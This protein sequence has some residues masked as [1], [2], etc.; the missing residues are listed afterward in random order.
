MEQT[1]LNKLKYSS[2][3]E[4]FGKM[5]D[6][7][8]KYGDLPFDSLMSAFSG[9]SMF[10]ND[11]YSQNA[12]IKRISTSPISY[13]KD[14]VAGFLKTPYTSEAELRQTEH[15]L[16]I[17]S[18]PLYHIRRTYTSM[19]TY[20]SF[21]APVLMDAEDMKAKDFWRE[22]RLV[23]KLRRTFDPKTF[24]HRTGGQAQQEGKV[25][26]I[27]RAD[28]DKPHN[29]VNHA[30][31]QQLPSDFCKIV[32]FNNKSKYTIAFNLMYF[33]L[34]GTDPRQFG[35]LF[36]P[37]MQD[38]NQVVYPEP[39]GVGGKLVY[40][41]A[42]KINLEKI[43]DNEADAYYQN[44]KWFYWVT[45]PITKVHTIEADDVS[46]AVFSPFSGLFINMIQLSQIEALQ[47]QLYQNP[48]IAIGTG[49][50]EMFD[51]RATNDADPIK[52]SNGGRLFFVELW[53]QLMRT[54]NTGGIPMYFAPARNMKIQSLNEVAHTSE[55]VS[56]SVQ[57]TISEAGLSAIVPSS[58][59][60]RAGAVQ[61]SFQIESRFLTVIYQGVER[62]FN[63]MLEAMGLKYDWEFRMFGTIPE[64]GEMEESAMKGMEHGILPDAI[65]YN[66][67]KDRSIL[68]DM[69]WTA[70]V[71]ESGIMEK[72]YPL[73]SSYNAK[74]EKAGIPPQ[75]GRPKSEGVTSEGNEGDLDGGT[76]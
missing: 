25:F 26:Y 58:S 37:Y 53:N 36:L 61:V 55:I 43:N 51:D 40:A 48:M 22:Y 46:S 60:T 72:R 67:L 54:N 34:P 32:G 65:I 62:L 39:K 73:I 49:E 69:C 5:R 1:E 30:F 71:D 68:D 56:Q 27:W 23:E 21:V 44:G 75:G 13:G 31:A 6:L 9:A 57:D 63:C 64:D 38:F 14:E 7:E 29:K 16:E 47:L 15:A 18:Y 20:H 11:P 8:S 12:R 41:S 10:R 17:S 24:A 74:Q 66:A 33:T 50:L 28:L 70:L 52:L 42:T 59:D 2:Y 4:I 76:A 35:D 3:S 19:L 45:L